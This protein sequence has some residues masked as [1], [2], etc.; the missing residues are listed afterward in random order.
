MIRKIRL[1]CLPSRTAVFAFGVGTSGI[2]AL[3]SFEDFDPCEAKSAGK[4]SGTPTAR[5]SIHQAKRTGPLSY[6]Q[7]FCQQNGPQ[8][9][10]LRFTLFSLRIAWQHGLPR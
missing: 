3:S 9:N 1:G 2:A 7:H 8:I 5:A 10:R 4:F 6:S